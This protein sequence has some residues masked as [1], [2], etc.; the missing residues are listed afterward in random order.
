MLL[1]QL[2]VTNKMPEVPP[3]T[4]DSN[5][6][7]RAPI[8]NEKQTKRKDYCNI[9]TKMDTIVRPDDNLSLTEKIVFSPNS[10]EEKEDEN[11]SL[12]NETEETRQLAA[13]TVTSSSNCGRYFGTANVSTVIRS[14]ETG[15]QQQQQEKFST[16]YISLA[17]SIASPP[18]EH[19]LVKT[20]DA[21]DLIASIAAS[22]RTPQ[23]PG[24]CKVALPVETYSSAVA[25]TDDHTAGRKSLLK[26]GKE[27]AIH[28]RDI[29]MTDDD[30][31]LGDVPWTME[32]HQAFVAAIFE[33]GLKTCSPSIIMENMRKQPRYV[34]RERTKSHLQ[35]Y[36]ITKD[37]NKEDFMAEYSEF[38]KKTESI[39]AQYIESNNRE[40]IPKVV[41]SK[42][43]GG[44]RATKLI[45]GQAAALLSFSV[46]NNCSTD[47]GPD[48]IPF[49]G[50]K[51]AFPNLTDEEKQTSL[52]ASLLYI[53]GLLHNMTDVLLKQRHGLD[54]IPSVNA[55]E[56]DSQSSSEEEDYSDLE[57]EVVEAK[58]PLACD[59]LRKMSPVPGEPSG[60]KNNLRKAS[61]DGTYSYNG[62]YQGKP[63][64]HYPPPPFPQQGPPGFHHPFP[65]FA[66]GGPQRLM[67]LPHGTFP[68]HHPPHFH[69]GPYGHPPPHSMNQYPTGPPH[70]VPFHG[71]NE[72][73][74]TSYHNQ[75][76]YYPPDDSEPITN[77]FSYE[78]SYPDMTEQE[79]HES[80]RNLVSRK[81]KKSGLERVVSKKTTRK[82]I[83]E[84][85]HP[86][87]LLA[88]PLVADRKR[89]RMDRRFDRVT[90][91]DL[92]LE[93]DEDRGIPGASK[94]ASPFHESR[95]SCRTKF[96]QRADS[97]QMA[98]TPTEHRGKS[99]L[100]MESPFKEVYESIKNEDRSLSNT[101]EPGQQK[102]L[103]SSNRRSSD[104]KLSPDMLFD[105]EPHLSPG[106]MSLAS[107]MSNDGHR[108]VWE[109]LAIDIKDQFTD[110]ERFRPPSRNVDVDGS[111]TRPAKSSKSNA[112]SSHNASPENGE[113]FSRRNFFPEEC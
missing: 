58:P 108:I 79:A 66:F 6:L 7:K 47:H 56:Y 97:E 62:P 110:Q 49:H 94:V 88:S 78:E 112:L 106:E 102:T 52:G 73:Q 11:D 63:H 44:K 22:T 1:V 25:R 12:K 76:A 92:S 87:N 13:T 90:P 68:L 2:A 42:A 61:H 70:P 27:T 15:V 80:D 28:T 96:R 4:V 23:S 31:L 84:P 86:S 35:K 24:S 98:I 55:E 53:K 18:K 75:P 103:T 57:E 33:V 113:S 14:S 111:P 34:T 30:T 45:G 109:P 67:P 104:N 26:Q 100:F 91:L 85:D 9:E 48:Q 3:E 29:K 40:P 60:S 81:T 99:S 36:R 64:G 17:S 51:T 105:G 16:R 54:N 39:K 43:L 32:Q 65:P 19:L 59:P 41:L 72:S 10:R 95:S 5:L 77:H 93:S 89:K 82:N 69:H 107:K 37:R 101:K 20:D 50:T 46:L 71:P 83:F 74:N 8:A 21:N 38:M